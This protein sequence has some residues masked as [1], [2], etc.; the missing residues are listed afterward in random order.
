MTGLPTEHAGSWMTD[1]TLKCR[2][3]ECAA[4][5]AKWKQMARSGVA[6]GEMQRM[7]CA[8][9]RS[10]RERRNRLLDNAD[11]RVRQEPYLS[12]PFIHKNNEPK[13]HAMLLRAAEHAKAARSYILWFQAIDIPEN[14][15]QIAGS[16]EKLGKRLQRFLQ[17]HDQQTAGLPGLN[18]RYKGMKARVTEKLVKNENMTILKRENCIIVGWSLHPAD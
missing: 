11:A 6:W 9:C 15:A 3:N 7:E 17:F 18:I 1:G 2:S 12:A 14:P 8:L 4:L 16:T 5:P 13:Y 10:E